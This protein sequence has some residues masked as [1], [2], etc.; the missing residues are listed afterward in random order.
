MSA[1]E[2]RT[3]EEW[4]ALGANAPMVEPT[5]KPDPHRCD[6]LTPGTP[7]WARVGRIGHRC[8][9]CGNGCGTTDCHIACCGTES[10][11]RLK[12]L[13]GSY[14]TGH[15]CS[16]CHREDGPA[17]HVDEYVCDVELML[18]LHDRAAVVAALAVQ[19]VEDYAGEPVQL[20]YV[21]A[22]AIA[23]LTPPLEA[24]P[25]ML[26]ADHLIEGYYPEVTGG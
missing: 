3:P 18:T 11:W 15:P 19:L 5:D 12:K 20:A 24:M 9:K 4:L 1:M 16:A 13:D 8:E 7:E 6:H 23:Q 17:D 10:K 25:S 21:A 26:T 22:E 14:C 2:T